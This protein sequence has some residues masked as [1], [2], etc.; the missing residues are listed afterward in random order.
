MIKTETKMRQRR[1][2]IVVI[3][4]FAFLVLNSEKI[5]AR[6]NNKPT[7]KHSTKQANSADSPMLIK[8]AGEI[9]DSLY[10]TTANQ[11]IVPA[12]GACTFE[13][14]NLKVL[15]IR[16]KAGTSSQKIQR[17]LTSMNLKNKSKSVLLGK[18]R[19]EDETLY[20]ELQE[21]GKPAIHGSALGIV[22]Y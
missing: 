21:K 8:L 11:S 3:V 2:F 22:D 14:T 18:L 9:I 12:S 7:S 13:I 16:F 19:W 17:A 20:V 5:L 6:E 15:N 10:N 1:L 4:C